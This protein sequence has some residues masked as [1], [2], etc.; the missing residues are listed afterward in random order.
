MAISSLLAT[1][2][3]ACAPIPAEPMKA[4]KK[5][6][7]AFHSAYSI[8]KKGKLIYFNL[9]KEEVATHM[10]G[11]A[12]ENGSGF[13]PPVRNQAT[14]GYLR[15]G[16]GTNLMGPIC[17]FSLCRSAVFSQADLHLLFQTPGHCSHGLH[18]APTG[19]ETGC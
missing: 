4:G 18:P 8:W 9:I 15:F 2:G 5:K 17:Y 1:Y 14:N 10:K 3:C 12:G 19:N 13:F 6:M 11:G 16:T 7:V